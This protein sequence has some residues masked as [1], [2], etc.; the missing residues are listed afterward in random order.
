MAAFFFGIT[1]VLGGGLSFLSLRA[2]KKFNK[3]KMNQV[4]MFIVGCLTGTSVI[5]LIAN[6]IISYRDFG[7]PYMIASPF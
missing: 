5:A 6:I 4:L 1:F 2:V 3:N 7:A